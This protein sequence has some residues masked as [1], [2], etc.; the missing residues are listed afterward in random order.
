MAVKRMGKEFDT[1]RCRCQ[2]SEKAKVSSRGSSFSV[3]AV[4]STCL[5]AGLP[6]IPKG[7]LKARLPAISRQPP[8]LAGGGALQRDETSCPLSTRFSA[9]LEQRRLRRE[10]HPQQHRNFNP[11]GSPEALIPEVKWP[12]PQTTSPRSVTKS[13]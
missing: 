10:R 5:M 11:A 8:A 1:V 12:Q 6:A 9:G 3:K 13:N 4:E 2:R 7:I